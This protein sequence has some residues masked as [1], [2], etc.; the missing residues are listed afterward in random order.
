MI[1]NDLHIFQGLR[2]DSHQIRQKPEYLWDAHNIRLT[3][4]EDSTQLSIT[5]ERGTDDTG[6][7]FIGEYVGHCVLGNILVVFTNDGIN[8]RIY[9]VIDNEGVYSM[10]C[11][12]TDQLGDKGWTPDYPIEAFGFYESSLI[13]KVYW[14]DGKHQPRV[15]N[16][17]KDGHTAEEFDFLQNL[18]LDEVV[19]VTESRGHGMF[20]PG[21]IQY[22][23]SY[24]N[25]YGQET[26]L[27][28]TTPLHYITYKDRG[29]SPEDRI[30][31]SFNITVDKVE[32][33]DYMRIYSIHRTSLDAVPV[34]KIISDVEI[35]G[36][37]VRVVDTG[38]IGETVDPS[39]LFYI[40]GREIVPHCMTHKDNT[41]FFGNIEIKED[42]KFL[43]VKRALEKE[44][45]IIWNDVEGQNI[46]NDVQK[47]VYYS[48]DIHPDIRGFKSNEYYRLG[49]QFQRNTGSWTE[50]VFLR[51][52]ILNTMFPY[53]NDSIVRWNTKS[54]TFSEEL[55]RLLK[56]NG[57]VKA[58]TCVVFP[59]FNDRSI[60]CQGVIC[61]TV[62][63]SIGRSKDGP[64]AMSSWF[65]RA[66]SRSDLSG[67]NPDSLLGSDIQYVH[68]RTLLSASMGSEI[69]GTGNG[70]KD[71]SVFKTADNPLFFVDE[72]IVTMHSP[73]IEFDDSMHYID[74]YSDYSLHILG[75]VQM[76]AVAGDISVATSTPKAGS[77]GAGFMHSYQGYTVGQTD[78]CSNG[79]LV[80]SFYNDTLIYSDGELKN[81]YIDFLIYP[82]NR[83]GSLNNDVSR[84]EGSRTAV[85][86]KKVISNLKYFNGFTPI[87]QNDLTVFDIKNPQ[88]FSSD[89]VQLTKIWSP[90]L[91]KNVSYFGNVDML[92]TFKGDYHLYCREYNKI[93]TVLEAVVDEPGDL[94]KIPNR[95]KEPV[96]IKY[97]S[98]PHLVFSLGKDDSDIYL[99]PASADNGVKES[100]T[101]VIPEWDNTSQTPSTKPWDNAID[102]GFLGAIY[103]KY[104]DVK[105]LVGRY[106]IR[107]WGNDLHME[108]IYRS[109]RTYPYWES[110]FTTNERTIKKGTYIRVRGNGSVIIGVNNGIV[111]PNTDIHTAYYFDNAYEQGTYVGDD[112]YFIVDSVKVSNTNHIVTIREV[113]IPEDSPTRGEEEGFKVKRYSV[114]QKVYYSELPYMCLA[115]L[116]R[117]VPD[118]T[119]FGG[120]S[121]YILKSHLW[122]PSS[123]PVSIDGDIPYLY[124]DTWY[125][126]YDCLKT[127]PFTREDANQIVEIGSFMCETRVNIDGR[128]DRN[129]GQV[130]NLDM[131]PENFNHIND[132]Y[133]QK[134][135][136][137]NYRILEESFYRNSVFS[138]QIAWSK[139]KTVGET[140]DTWTNVTLANTLDMNG[141]M[142]KVTSLKV[143]NDAVICLQ[144]KAV[145]QIMFNNRVQI[146]VSDGV[147]I[148]ISNGNKVDGYRIISDS[149]GCQNKWSAVN[150]SGGIFFIDSLTDG[151]YAFNGQLANISDSLGAKWW[152]QN[153]HSNN[154]WR[155]Y[156][157]DGIRSFYDP[158]YRDI[159]FTPG[160]SDALCYSEHLNCFVSQFSYGGTQ[161]MFPFNDEFMSLRDD[162]KLRLY[163]N[164][165]GKYND[166]F[167]ETKGWDITLISN[168]NPDR[169]KVFDNIEL[170]TDS[171]DEDDSLLYSSPLGYIKAFNEY[172]SSDSI[173]DNVNMR[174]KFR[175]WRGLIPRNS[176]TMQRIRN[177]WSG[178]T[179]GVKDNANNNKVY[180]HDVNVKYTV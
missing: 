5:N 136:F 104:D 110:S 144:D 80:N 77:L 89:E 11:I 71:I 33:F 154:E 17:A 146:P 163:R 61:P 76:Q 178:I 26:N 34:V 140:I 24:Y 21:V 84:S 82:F 3:N 62:Y 139:E 100:G 57:Y 118:H 176:G 27:F 35:K 19:E 169:I 114:P 155:P 147:P 111:E 137:F 60:L 73:D 151:I 65:F 113:E 1:Q 129:R 168:G 64:Y 138:N 46:G 98:T 47:G 22:A 91:N 12:F 142:G 103:V 174:R 63:S 123:E 49:V 167:G 48:Y 31:T 78:G 125:S 40:G 13:Q 86:S 177:L 37:T 133:S 96:R 7:S 141:E 56:E 94:D 132:V 126:R 28:Y 122:Y 131:S 165:K 148:E 135:S 83:E 10:E 52:D 50:P 108:V 8:S 29:G 79:G 160:N 149:V 107:K 164:F 75:F 20:A 156:G 9:K 158:L 166:F 109:Y 66:G 81:E 41:L 44:E 116:R 45:N 150:T 152:V 68:N 72:N 95:S 14:I 101:Y 145:S 172:Q 67:G 159:Y 58:R 97:K 85:L 39:Y 32:D 105:P 88:L 153:N 106:S 4:R 127:Y 15:I 115:E 128:Y 74:E 121:P 93:K 38:N 102:I 180:I 55:R 59:S 130:S 30:S 157:S 18:T 170:R 90:Y 87:G 162:G 120:D 112:L 143:F 25:R 92:A 54:I 175:V 43:G 16:V 23:F 53:I 117:D 99:P 2:R 6:I 42:D 171:W 36:N 70:N 134:D 161:A 51:D 124:G 119:R 69:Q 173:F 179:L